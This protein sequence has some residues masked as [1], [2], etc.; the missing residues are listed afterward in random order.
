MVLLLPMS[1]PG[2]TAPRLSTFSVGKRT[3][4][5]GSARGQ[6]VA[7]RADDLGEFCSQRKTKKRGKTTATD[8]VKVDEKRD[9]GGRMPR[10]KL[11]TRSGSA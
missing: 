9:E 11:N 10:S 3:Q 6:Q 5:G 2:A 1:S 8:N 7:G 4:R